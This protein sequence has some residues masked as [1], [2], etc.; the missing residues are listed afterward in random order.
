MIPSIF[1]NIINL[2]NAMVMIVEFF[3]FV[4]SNLFFFIVFTL[5]MKNLFQNKLNVD[6]VFLCCYQFK[7]T[8][9]IAVWNKFVLINHYKNKCIIILGIKKIQLI[10]DLVIHSKTT[11]TFHTLKKK[12]FKTDNFGSH[13][14]SAYMLQYAHWMYLTYI[15]CIRLVY[16]IKIY[17]KCKNEITSCSMNWVRCEKKYLILIF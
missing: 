17:V 11:Q 3:F 10:K 12:I 1:I 7:I 5:V 13:S 4:L 15:H 9:K 8:K 6:G 2:H 16:L 14:F